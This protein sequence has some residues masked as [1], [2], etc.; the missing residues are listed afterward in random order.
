MWGQAHGPGSAA[1]MSGKVLQ[2]RQHQSAWG[3]RE[4]W[5]RIG[6]KPLALLARHLHR[7]RKEACL[8][9]AMSRPVSEGRQQRGSC[10]AG[11]C[12]SLRA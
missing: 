8:A 5:R 10:P 11:C 4:W 2:V 12:P 7:V 1:E 6:Y 3:N 9:N